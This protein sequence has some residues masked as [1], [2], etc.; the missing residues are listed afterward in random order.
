M[1]RY[2]TYIKLRTFIAA[3]SQGHGL[4]FAAGCID[5]FQR[6]IDIFPIFSQLKGTAPGG[7]A[8]IIA[9]G[10][11]ELQTEPGRAFAAHFGGNI[12]RIAR[13]RLE[14]F[15][16][17]PA[18][19][20]TGSNV[21]YMQHFATIFTDDLVLGK[22]LVSCPL[23]DPPVD[24]LAGFIQLGKVAVYLQ[25]ATMQQSRPQQQRKNRSDFSHGKLLCFLLM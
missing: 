12:D 8:H 10:I 25:C 21:G 17:K 19:T 23:I 5:H 3:Q 1:H 2:I 22:G 13:H 24:G 4:S 15:A 18:E 14:S 20:G 6:Q 7:V 16:V 11:A 9:F